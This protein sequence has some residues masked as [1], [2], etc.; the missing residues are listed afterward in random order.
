M[1][2]DD[3]VYD[4]VCSN[5]LAHDLLPNLNKVNLILI[6]EGVETMSCGKEDRGEVMAFAVR[7]RVDGKEKTMICPHCKRSGHDANL[8]LHSLDTPSGGVI[9]RAVTER[10]EVVVG[11]RNPRY[12]EQKKGQTEAVVLCES[13]Q[14]R[15]YLEA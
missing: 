12:S 15:P 1:G 7:G 6:Q 5:I 8:A 14:H 4:T 3:T 2:L 13:M 11:D 10:M 9:D